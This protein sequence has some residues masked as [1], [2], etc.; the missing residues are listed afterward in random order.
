M[1]NSDVLAAEIVARGTSAYVRRL[2]GNAYEDCFITLGFC[3]T[4]DNAHCY[5]PPEF[6]RQVVIH[7]AECV[8]RSRV[9]EWTKW[10]EADSRARM[11]KSL[12][13]GPRPWEQRQIDE[14]ESYGWAHDAEL[15]SRRA[16]AARGG[17]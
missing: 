13:Q 11:A 5:Q 14:V 16:A 9:F 10:S 12:N 6:E 15:D 7:S 1:S 4:C 8:R 17:A 3:P 2:V